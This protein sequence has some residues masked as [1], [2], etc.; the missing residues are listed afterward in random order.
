MRLG[1]AEEDL[2]E[3]GSDRLIDAVIPHGSAEEVGDAVRAHLA[4]GASHVCLQPLGH[5]PHP[6]EDYHALSCVL[7]G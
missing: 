3:G 1:F 2:A 4:A 6:I 7:I 5:G